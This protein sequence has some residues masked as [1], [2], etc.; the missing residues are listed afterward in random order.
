ERPDSIVVA[1]NGSPVILG[2]G[3]REMFVAFD[4]AALVRHTQRVVHL[5][6]GEVAVVRADGYETSTLA[7]GAT[8]KT[9]LTVTF[10]AEAIDKG[11]HAHFMRKES[12]EQPDAI[13][14]TLSGRLEERFATAHLGGLVTAAREL[15]EGGAWKILRLRLRDQQD[16]R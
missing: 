5:D 1:R 14:R 8:V 9:P 15:L 11:E 3:E 16:A 13:R 6:D 10:G 12:A 4:A 2:I 7:G